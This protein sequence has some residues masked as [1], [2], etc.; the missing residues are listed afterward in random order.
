M[1]KGYRNGLLLAFA[2]FKE[3]G[4]NEAVP[5]QVAVRQKQDTVPFQHKEASPLG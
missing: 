4:V 5:G 2:V 3:Q 1:K